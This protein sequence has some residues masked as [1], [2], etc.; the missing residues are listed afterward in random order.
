MIKSGLPR[1]E[2]WD[3]SE[4]KYMHA[5]QSLVAWKCSAEYCVHCDYDR[6]H[7]VWPPNI[8]SRGRHR[9]FESPIGRLG[10]LFRYFVSRTSFRLG[11]CL[12][13]CHSSDKDDDDNSLDY[14]NKFVCM[15]N[16]QPLVRFAL[17]QITF[18]TGFGGSWRLRQSVRVMWTR[19]P[20]LVRRVSCATAYLMEPFLDNRIYN[21]V[22]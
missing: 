18:H 10:V 16:T 15:H 21:F 22:D 11:L 4:T 20:T 6:H 3:I 13:L 5:I 2:T 9:S 8:P 12:W 1:S 19:R 7:S 14:C 17:I